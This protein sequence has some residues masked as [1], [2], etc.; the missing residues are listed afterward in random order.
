M[1]QYVS[2]CPSRRWEKGKA[3]GSLKN[4]PAAKVEANPLISFEVKPMAGE[5]PAL[6]LANSKRVFKR[7]WELLEVGKE[8]V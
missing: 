5:D 6:V 8:S 3:L 1:Y 7:A 4:D 2:S